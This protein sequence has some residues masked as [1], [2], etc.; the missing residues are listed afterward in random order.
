MEMVHGDRKCLM[1]FLGN[2]S[3]GHRTCL[4]TFYDLV[5][6][7]YFVDRDRF[8]RIIEFQKSTKGSMAFLVYDFC[9]FF[10]Q[11]I[12]S[13][14]CRF[15]KEMNSLRIVTMFLS[16]ASH[17]VCTDTVK[18]QV[19]VQSQRVKCF[20]VKSVYVLFDIFQCD[21]AYTTYSSGK[22]FVDHFFGDT[23][24]LEDLRSLIRLDCGNTHL[25]CDLDD[26]A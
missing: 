2:R 15:L 21:S 26:A 12:A 22:V 25:G 20:G 7:L 1:C 8:F 4:E 18:C 14:S 6:T 17:L 24:R 23:D 10:E 9:I 11:C 5:Y 19:C 13:C 3:V 16:L